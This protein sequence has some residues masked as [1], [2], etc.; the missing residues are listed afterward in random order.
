[1]AMPVFGSVF[2]NRTPLVVPVVEVEVPPVVLTTQQQLD[3]LWNYPNLAVGS[4]PFLD[5]NSNVRGRLPVLSPAPYGSS[6]AAANR[7]FFTNI[8]RNHWHA[9]DLRFGGT[10]Q[11][12][13]W[14]PGPGGG[15][16]VTTQ[17]RGGDAIASDNDG[18]RADFTVENHGRFAVITQTGRFGNAWDRITQVRPSVGINTYINKATQS[19]AT[20]AQFNAYLAQVEALRNQIAAE[21]AAPPAEEPADPLADLELPEIDVVPVPADVV[22]PEANEVVNDVVTEATDQPEFFVP[23]AS[24]IDFGL[25][26]YFDEDENFIELTYGDMLVARFVIGTDV[27]QV[28]YGEN[29]ETV[30]LDSMIIIYEDGNVYAPLEFF[31][32]ALGLRIALPEDGF[33]YDAE[34]GEDDF[35]N[36][37]EVGEDE[38]E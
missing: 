15:T 25:D 36:D 7:Q 30:I 22:P 28:G 6:Y 26:V 35:D 10:V 16:T 13:T 38:D 5:H 18:F 24:A 4:R 19:V 8:F 32:N 20:Q 33:D 23:I 12:T 11:V 14:V 3:A 37:A 31:I 27:V 1:M 2:A 17:T 21:A 34:V 9:S 29:T